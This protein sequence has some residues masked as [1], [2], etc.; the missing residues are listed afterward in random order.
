T[1][2]K[3]TMK[4]A[5]LT[6]IFNFWNSQNSSQLARTVSVTGV[7]VTALP[8]S[9]VPSMTSNATQRALSLQQQS[10]PKRLT[11]IKEADWHPEKA[12][13]EDLPIY[14]R[15]SIE[16]KVM[17]KRE[18]LNRRNVLSG[19]ELGAVLA[20]VHYWERC[21]KTRFTDLVEEKF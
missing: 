2:W 9:A 18:T 14:L 1:S 10:N 19:M 7:D 17:V 21:L 16:W 8:N 6:Y 11:F 13:N 15:C 3:L 12:Y 4:M 5:S 20:P